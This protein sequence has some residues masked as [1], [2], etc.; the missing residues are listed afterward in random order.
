[1]IITKEELIRTLDGISNRAAKELEV[2]ANKY[3]ISI[4]KER[5]DNVI[6]DYINASNELFNDVQ[7]RKAMIAGIGLL[8]VNLDDQQQMKLEPVLKEY[9]DRIS[10][11]HSYYADMMK[12]EYLKRTESVFGK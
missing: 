2:I 10:A 12:N 8:M 1:M 5:F 9:R 11:L 6:G 7:A 4:D 3:V